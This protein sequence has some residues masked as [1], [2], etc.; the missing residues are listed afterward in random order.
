M[1]RRNNIFFRLVFAAAAMMLT[2]QAPMLEAEDPEI[3]PFLRCV[4]FSDCHYTLNKALLQKFANDISV[5]ADIIRMDPEGNY[6]DSLRLGSVDLIVLKYNDSLETDGSFIASRMFKDS[7]AWLARSVKPHNMQTVNLWISD[8]EGASYYDQTRW[9]LLRGLGG[10]TIS[11]FDYLIK[12]NAA[13]IGWD[14]RLISAIMA[15]ESGYRVGAKSS[16]GAIGLMQIL[17]GG[18]YSADTLWDPA[19]NIAVGTFKLYKY[20]R[21]YLA[22]GADSLD[23]IKMT[24]A[25]YNGGQGRIK[26]CIDY[27]VENEKDPSKWDNIAEALPIVTYYAGEQ[28]LYYVDKVLEKYGEY[29]ILY[30]L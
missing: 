20:Q 19:V 5:N 29:Q 30:P 11:P 22:L 24:L 27:V 9:S 4:I 3:N 28:M 21:T 7:T 17:P 6:L 25:A 12:K 2:P 15:T 10:G 14:W 16:A 1:K 26:R 13:A 23:C 18:Y 8:L